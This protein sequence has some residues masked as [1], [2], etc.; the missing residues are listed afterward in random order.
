MASRSGVH[1]PALPRER[2]SDVQDVLLE[3][4]N[5]WFGRARLNARPRLWF[6][7]AVLRPWLGFKAQQVRPGGC[8]HGAV[9]PPAARPVG[10]RGVARLAKPLVRRHRREWEAGDTGARRV[11]A[12]AGAARR[13]Q[14][15]GAPGGLTGAALG[16]LDPHDLLWGGP[17]RDPRAVPVAAWAHAAARERLMVGRQMRIVRHGQGPAARPDQLGMAVVGITGLMTDN[18]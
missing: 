12:T 10:P 18:Q 1:G 16:W 7:T 14:G 15:S 11:W 3:G 9:T 8:R 17:A 6:S 5:P 2:V 13:D 4:L